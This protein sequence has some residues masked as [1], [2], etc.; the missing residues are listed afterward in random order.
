MTYLETREEE[1][2]NAIRW[3]GEGSGFE[4]SRQ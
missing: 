2:R 1:M 4:S 3:V